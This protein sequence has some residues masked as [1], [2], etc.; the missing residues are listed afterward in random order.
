MKYHV[1]EL[2]DLTEL[3]GLMDT[4]Y[5]AT[6]INHA[7]LDTEGN[8]LTAAGWQKCCTDFHRADAECAKRCHSS[9]QYILKHLHDGPYVSYECHN[10]LFEYATPVIIGGTHVATIFTGQLLHQPPDLV[11]FAKQGREFSFDEEGYLAAIRNIKIVP[12]ERMPDIMSFLVQLAESLSKSGLARLRQLEANAELETI[13]QSRTTKLVKTINLLQTEISARKV[14]EQALIQSQGELRQLAANQVRAKEDE[15]KRIAREI[16]DELGQ[17]VLAFRLDVSA[18][19]ARTGAR[20]PRLNERCH[21]TLQSIDS[22]IRSVKAIINDLRPAVLDLGLSAA[23]EW[24]V[25]EFRRRSG[26]MCKLVMDEKMPD[27]DDES[28]TTAFRIVQES[29]TNVQRHARAKMV[30]VELLIRDAN[31]LIKVSDDGLGIHPNCRRKANAFGLVGINERVR[32]MGGEF[33]IA[34]RPSGGTC[35]SVSIP[36]T[37]SRPSEQFVKPD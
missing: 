16:H 9:D 13:V 30:E 29:L 32:I 7:L 10:G 19:H 6:E 25:K 1:S 26:M 3:Q 4:F 27:L 14:A 18:L 35:L 8:V 11:R 20:H 23:I 5:R 33:N 17:T 12:Q 21:T 2:I 36:L 37:G 34:S 31:F 22:T 15:R 28:T 24:L